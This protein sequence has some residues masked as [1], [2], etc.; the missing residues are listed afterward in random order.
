MPQKLKRTVFVQKRARVSARE[1][2]LFSSFASRVGGRSLNCG[3]GDDDL[4]PSR[5]HRRPS[6]Q[7]MDI[8]HWTWIGYPKRVSVVLSFWLWPLNG[9]PILA[10]SVL[11]FSSQTHPSPLCPALSSC[12]GCSGQCRSMLIHIPIPNPF[13]SFFSLSLIS[14]LSSHIAHSLFARSFASTKSKY[15]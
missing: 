7:H 8:G 11:I 14:L 5:R 6:L 9:V 15:I 12:S 2:G 1:K 3:R 13:L 4:I 10:N